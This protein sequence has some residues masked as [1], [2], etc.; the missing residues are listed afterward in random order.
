MPKTA[1]FMNKQ[2]QITCYLLCQGRYQKYGIILAGIAFKL[3]KSNYTNAFSHQ[4]QILRCFLQSEIPRLLIKL[5]T[6]RV[7]NFT[8]PWWH[9][10]TADQTSTANVSLGNQLMYRNGRMHKLWAVL[11]C[12]HHIELVQEYVCCLICYLRNAL[13]TN[14]WKLHSLNMSPPIHCFAYL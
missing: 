14:A 12:T 4:W 7:G 11:S 3:S 8:A 13:N 5:K 6:W 1:H 2:Y 10:A 9:L